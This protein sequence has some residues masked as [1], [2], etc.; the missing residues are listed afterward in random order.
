MTSMFA[1]PSARWSRLAW[2]LPAFC[3]A[4]ALALAA[5]TL[6]PS[7]QN[8]LLAAAILCAL[9]WSLALLA[10]DL[11][12]GFAERAAFIV[13]TGLLVNA[14]LSWWFAAVL[15]A[16]LLERSRAAPRTYR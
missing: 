1:H 10:L 13:C 15:R 6:R 4:L 2:C 5:A 16:R 11:A 7:E 8:V 12:Q 3:S 9:P 14:S